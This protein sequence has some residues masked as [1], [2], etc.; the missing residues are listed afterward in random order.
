MITG[1]LRTRRPRRSVRRPAYPNGPARRRQPDPR[2]R[3]QRR[4][5]ARRQPLGDRVQVRP[6]G[7]HFRRPVRRDL[8]GGDGLLALQRR[9]RAAQRIVLA[10]DQRRPRGGRGLH[11][12]HHR[13]RGAA[14]QVRSDSDR[15]AALGRAGDRAGGPPAADARRRPR[16]RLL[17]QRREHVRRRQRRHL[18]A[19][20]R[21][22]PRR[23]QGLGGR[24]DLLARRLHGERKRRHGRHGADLSGGRACRRW[25][26]RS[27]AAQP[28]PT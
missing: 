26:R 25:S 10:G 20:Q 24:L 2:R 1:R 21:A 28:P 13:L 22:L 3:R 6:V 18:R 23:E 12:R 9:A 5:P 15:R 7:L 17:D 4:G 8:R 14:A 27:G 11:Q 16:G 19:L